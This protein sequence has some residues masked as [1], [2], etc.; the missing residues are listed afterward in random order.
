[1][2]KVNIPRAISK[3]LF[4]LLPIIILLLFFTQVVGTTYTP[5]GSMETTIMTGD[6]VIYNRLAYKS[7]HVARGDVVIAT[8]N[9]KQLLKRAVGIGGDVVSVKEHKLYVNGKEIMDTDVADKEF[10]VPDGEV[11]LVGDNWKNSD[12]SLDWDNPYIP[13]RDML[14]KVYLSLGTNGGFHIALL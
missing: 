6:R 1:M 4:L 10:N 13:E 2:A 14:G 7:R 11:F 9:G 5:T 8:K 12:D 3:I